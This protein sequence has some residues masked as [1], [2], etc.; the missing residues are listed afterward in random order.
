MLQ[1]KSCENGVFGGLIVVCVDT[2]DSRKF[3]Y[4]FDQNGDNIVP[5]G[6]HTL[7][8]LGSKL[9]STNCREDIKRK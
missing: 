2:L 7:E 5:V 4:N 6:N 8:A 3:V 9:I 1:V